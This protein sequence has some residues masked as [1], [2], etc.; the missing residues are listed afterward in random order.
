MYG[1]LR[2]RY[3]GVISLMQIVKQKHTCVRDMHIHDFF[4]IKKGY[5]GVLVVH[6]TVNAN[7]ECAWVCFILKKQL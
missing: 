7:E 4:L 6:S 1:L 2:I 3:M 5:G